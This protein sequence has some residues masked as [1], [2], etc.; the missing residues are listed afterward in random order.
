MKKLLYILLSIAYLM[1]LTECHSGKEGETSALQSLGVE[2]ETPHHPFLARSEISKTHC[3]AYSTGSFLTPGP[4]G[5]SRSLGKKELDFFRSSPFLI[6]MQYSSPYS[7]GKQVIWAS[8]TDRVFKMDVGS[9]GFNLIDMLTIDEIPDAFRDENID[10]IK[11]VDGFKLSSFHAMLNAKKGK[12]LEK[13]VNKIIPN[14]DWK[15]VKYSGIYSVLDRDGNFYVAFDRK[16]LVFCDRD[17][18][19]RRSPILVSKQYELDSNLVHPEATIIG[20][21][22]TWDGHLV[23]LTTRGTVAVVSRDFAI[24]HYVRI[25]DSGIIRN[26]VTVDEDGGIYVACETKM[27][28]V[29]WTGSSLSTEPKHGAWEAAYHYSFDQEGSI[30]GSG[31][32]PSL[33]GSGEEDKFVVI[34]DGSRVQNLVLFWRDSVPVDWQQI[35]GTE[36]IRIAAQVPVTFGNS[37]IDFSFSEQ[38]VLVNGKGCLVVNNVYKDTRTNEKYIIRANDQILAHRVDFLELPKGIEKFE[39]NAANRT[40]SSVWVNSEVSSPSN[41]PAMSSGSNMV[42]LNSPH[43]DRWS[44]TGIDWTT[45]VTQFRYLLPDNGFRYNACSAEIQVLP[46][47]DIIHGTFYGIIRIKK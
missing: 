43:E 38:S 30:I 26:S 8:Q 11:L 47:G 6:S 15:E 21:S 16:I 36:E 17:P 3:N 19:D 37:D 24:D 32:T 28:R 1:L 9:K 7:D 20:L 42:Y 13:M 5:P 34:T 12:K 2:P 18:G 39:W 4:A 44:L 29:Q 14:K 40:L 23:I 25:K 41:V 10:N 33:M 35:P 22:M 31:S 45:G 27:C 46:N